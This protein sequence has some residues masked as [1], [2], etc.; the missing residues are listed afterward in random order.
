MKITLEKAAEGF[1]AYMAEQVA[2]I[3][4]GINRWLGFGALGSLK[5][6][7]GLLINKVRPYLEMVAVVEDN[8]VDIEAAR[9]FLNAAFS[10][11]PKLSYFNFTF[12]ADDAKALIAQMVKRAE[13]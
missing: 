2:T 9:D 11:E 12:T 6:N 10:N 4:N 8:M 1:I 3:P 13:E 5:N 7:P